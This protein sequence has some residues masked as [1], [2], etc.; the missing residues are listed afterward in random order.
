MG[1]ID[2]RGSM[3]FVV[4]GAI[5]FAGFVVGLMK[6][7]ALT[8]GYLQVL[9]SWWQLNVASTL[10]VRQIQQVSAMLGIP[11]EIVSGSDTSMLVGVFSAGMSWAVTRRR[12]HSRTLGA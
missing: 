11:M 12:N 2:F 10:E 6:A 3:V 1:E 7:E 5:F 8:S 4:L 9:R